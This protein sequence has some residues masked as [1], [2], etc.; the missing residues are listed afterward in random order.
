MAFA[1]CGP[2]VSDGLLPQPGG[3]EGI[4]PVEKSR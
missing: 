4:S 3:F 2:P 1:C